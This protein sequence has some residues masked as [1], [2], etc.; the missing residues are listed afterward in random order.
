M[1]RAEVLHTE[2]L[3]KSA[4]P[5]CADAC[6]MDLRHR[7]ASVALAVVAAVAGLA[8]GA[9]V[10]FFALRGP[11]T[12][13]ERMTRDSYAEDDGVTEA[14]MEEIHRETLYDVCLR[15]VCMIHV[16]D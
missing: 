5:D 14:M 9:C 3:P 10:A 13:L 12:A 7:R 1:Q 4:S 2:D 6:A 16:I 8:L 15:V 11:A